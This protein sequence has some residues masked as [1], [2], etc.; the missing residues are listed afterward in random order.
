MRAD[1]AVAFVIP[2][3]G[4]LLAVELVLNFV[5]ELYRPRVPGQEDRPSFDSRLFNII[6]QPG[7]VGHSIADALNYQFGFEVSKTW[8]YQLLGKALV[9]LVI[10]GAIVLATISSVVIVHNG[11]QVVVLHWGRPAGLLNPG[12]HLKWPWPAATVSRFNVDEVHQIILG[13][14]AER[15]PEEIRATI[16]QEGPQRGRELNI[17][18]QEHGKRKE[19]DFILANPTEGADQ[20]ARQSGSQLPVSLIRKIVKVRVAQNLARAPKKA[21]KAP[22]KPAG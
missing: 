18:T 10:F 13:E 6:A 15:R 8:F 22:R 9:P 12:L 1:Y 11:E 2:A 21:K 19:L 4:I 17:W 3:V 5:L 14:G 16:M 7:D 20:D